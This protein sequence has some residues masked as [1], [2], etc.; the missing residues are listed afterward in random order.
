MV[1][2]VNASLLAYRFESKCI[3]TDDI[4]NV[5]AVRSVTH[6]ALLKCWA[7]SLLVNSFLRKE[8]FWAWERTKSPGTEWKNQAS[9]LS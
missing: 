9:P 5:R 7:I 8:T 3:R 1:K 6:N 2:P 4:D